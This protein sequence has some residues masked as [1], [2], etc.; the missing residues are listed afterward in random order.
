MPFNKFLASSSFFLDRKGLERLKVGTS[1]PALSG[2]GGVT[3]ATT[4]RQRRRRLL[5]CFVVVGERDEEVSGIDTA[6]LSLDAVAGEALLAMER[7][8]CLIA[9]AERICESEKRLEEMMIKKTK[10]DDGDESSRFSLSRILVFS[11]LSMPN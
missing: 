11:R 1:S 5:K 8:G 6:I 7:R 9:V 10:K 3:A 4:E 2:E